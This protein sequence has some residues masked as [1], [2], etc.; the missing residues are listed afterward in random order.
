MK[1]FS[2]GF[3]TNLSLYFHFLLKK[4]LA[5]ECVL[6]VAIY[7]QK[8]FASSDSL[9]Q[10]LPPPWLVRS[11]SK[12]SRA[13]PQPASRKSVS[14]FVVCAV[15]C[16]DGRERNDR[17][18]TRGTRATPFWPARFSQFVAVPSKN[19]DRFR[20]SWEESLSCASEGKKNTGW[21]RSG[22]FRSSSGLSNRSKH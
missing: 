6:F 11:D 12:T 22:S 18:K 9:T 2:V 21:T 17:K 4:N 3:V 20:N 13:A 7:V 1:T 8:D 10:H 15:P 5:V 14:H 19:Q 16:R